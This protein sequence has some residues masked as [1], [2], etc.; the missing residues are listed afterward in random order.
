VLV[1]RDNIEHLLII[2]GRTDVLVESNVVRPTAAREPAR[3]LASGPARLAARSSN[4]L[5]HAEGSAPSQR[6][7]AALVGVQSAPIAKMAT[8]PQTEDGLAELTRQLEAALNRPSAPEGRSPITHSPTV[9]PSVPKGEPVAA[10]G[11]SLND[12]ERQ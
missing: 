12:D 5:T 10:A 9:P 11:G 1:R 6:S 8:S 4:R 2:G 3:P 7:S